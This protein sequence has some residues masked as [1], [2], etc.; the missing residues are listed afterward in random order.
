MHIASP[1]GPHISQGPS[2]NIG[3]ALKKMDLNL[4]LKYM[5]LSIA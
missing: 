2:V 4:F 5:A 3:P 1:C